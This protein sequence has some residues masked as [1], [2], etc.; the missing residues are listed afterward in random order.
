MYVEGFGIF[1]ERQVLGLI[2]EKINLHKIRTALN[3]E[4]APRED[5]GKVIKGE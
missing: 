4:E 2:Q 1:A 5:V 3:A